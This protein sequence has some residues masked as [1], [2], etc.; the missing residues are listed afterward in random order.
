MLEKLNY[1]LDAFENP[2]TPEYI[3]I[4]SGLTWM[5]ILA[6]FFLICLKLAEIF[7]V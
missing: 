1:L 7:Y 2:K 4:L 5:L 6:A 3:R